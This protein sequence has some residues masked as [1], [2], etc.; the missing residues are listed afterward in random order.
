VRPAA[1]DEAQVRRAAEAHAL[2]ARETALRLAELKAR[3]VAESEP[4]ALVIGCDQLLTCEGIW[5]EKPANVDAARA[6]LRALRGRAHVLMTAVACRQGEDVLWQHV[7]EPRLTMRHFSEAFLEDY[8]ALERR[9]VTA[10]VGAYRME[11]PGI[12]LFEAIEGEHAAILGLPLLPLLA[13]LRWWGV[14]AG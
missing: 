1:L 8:L 4:D 5:F 14:L 12:H 11:G 7:A 3:Q 10:S 2:S 9:D 13:F 6:Q